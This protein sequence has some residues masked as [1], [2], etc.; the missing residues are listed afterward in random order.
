MQ[1]E[2]SKEM[3]MHISESGAEH[4]LT[5]MQHST[6]GLSENVLAY[7]WCLGMITDSP[8]FHDVE[9]SSLDNKLCGWSP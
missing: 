1:E 9:H 7:I 2:L 5:S 8:S 6:S 4:I 3:E